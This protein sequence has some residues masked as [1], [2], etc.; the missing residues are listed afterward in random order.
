MVLDDDRTGWDEY[1]A[2]AGPVRLRPEVV[3]L[4]SESW[5]LTEIAIYVA[6]F[7]AS[8]DETEDTLVAWASL[9]D[10]LP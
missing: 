7:R 10:F 6:Q 2:G 4:Y 3:D 5:S 9:N 1:V 8:H